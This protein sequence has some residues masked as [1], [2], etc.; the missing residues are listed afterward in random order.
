[1]ATPTPTATLTLTPTRTPRPTPTATIT[2]TPSATPTPTLILNPT[3]AALPSQARPT[4][5]PGPLVQPVCA[6]YFQRPPST[7]Y[8]QGTWTDNPEA[9]GSLMACFDWMQNAILNKQSCAQPGA[10]AVIMVL[11]E[12]AR[13]AFDLPDDLNMDTEFVAQQ[14]CL[15]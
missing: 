2:P 15:P 13:H 6:A 9:I 10:A 3:L 1:V 12:K 4:V 7:D 5:T 11:I 14:A 8:I